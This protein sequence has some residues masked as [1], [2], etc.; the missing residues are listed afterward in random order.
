MR[1]SGRSHIGN[2]RG[3]STITM[4][5]MVLFFGALLTLLVKV[6]PF[7]L[8]DLTIQEAVESLDGTEGLSRMGPAQVMSLINKRLTVNNVRSLDP[9]SFKI[10]KNGELVIIKLV[11]E[12]RTNL[13]RNLDAVVS[14]NHEYEMKG[15]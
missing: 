7:Y 11:Y 13:F 2:Q 10:E 9:E 4:L 12:K 6:G 1:R 14:F 5:V 3:A 15:Q 8:D